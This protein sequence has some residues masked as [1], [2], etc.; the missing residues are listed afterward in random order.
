MEIIQ[1]IFVLFSFL[2]HTMPMPFNK[3]N[4]QLYKDILKK[5]TQV[6]SKLFKI[7]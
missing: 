6:V 1:N 4:F 5:Y 3:N 7:L 2:N